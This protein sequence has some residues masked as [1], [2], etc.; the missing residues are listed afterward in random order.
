M[1]LRRDHVHPDN[2]PQ[3]FECGYC[4]CPLLPGDTVYWTTDDA[5]GYCSRGCAERHGSRVAVEDWADG[6]PIAEDWFE[7]TALQIR[8]D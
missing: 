4:G 3:G 1:Q 5:D 6:D 8:L 2:G 7:A